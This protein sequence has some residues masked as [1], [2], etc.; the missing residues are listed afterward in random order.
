MFEA[1][2]WDLPLVGWF[3]S[4]LFD[5]EDGNSAVFRNAGKLLPDYTASYRI[6][7]VFFILF[8]VRSAIVT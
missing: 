2:I 8:V 7:I 3:F 6:E 1:I 5:P 4:L